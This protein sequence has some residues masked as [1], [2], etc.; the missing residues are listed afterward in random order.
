MRWKQEQTP[1]VRGLDE[2]RGCFMV[3]PCTNITASNFI[4]SLWLWSSLCSCCPVWL[5]P[6]LSHRFLQLKRL[7][8]RRLVTWRQRFPP[9]LKGND[10]CQSVRRPSS[11]SLLS[12]WGVSDY[13]FCQCVCGNLLICTN[14]DSNAP[15]TAAFLADGWLG[16]RL[17]A[18]S[19]GP[20]LGAGNI[21]HYTFSRGREANSHH[22]AACRCRCNHII[23]NHRSVT[24]CLRSLGSC[25]RAGWSLIKARP[26]TKW[27]VLNLIRGDVKQTIIYPSRCEARPAET[28]PWMNLQPLPLLFFFFR[29][30][31]LFFSGS[32]MHFLWRH[33]GRW[34]MAAWVFPSLIRHLPLDLIRRWAPVFS[35]RKYLL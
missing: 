2:P 19:A 1:A 35:T 33:H 23:L 6:P 16:C 25:Q 31:E 28:R 12:L 20:Q 10:L 9:A 7:G 32:C 14:T 34:W 13:M 5:S 27:H 24:R 26:K 8:R 29:K 15:A 11:L 21:A 4:F 3:L 17:M 30:L 18:E 22:G